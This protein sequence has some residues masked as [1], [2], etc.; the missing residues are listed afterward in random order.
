MKGGRTDLRLSST[1]PK[2]FELDLS[3]TSL[4]HFLVAARNLKHGEPLI[5]K[6]NNN[7][8]FDLQYLLTSPSP[9]PSPKSKPKSKKEKRD[10]DSGL[11]LKSYSPPQTHNNF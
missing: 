3:L 4:K 5:F 6:I 1:G 10:L 7:I 8:F 9:S 2:S 11:S